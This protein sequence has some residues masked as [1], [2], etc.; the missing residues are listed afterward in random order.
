MV[1][2]LCLFVIPQP[3]YPPTHPSD[4]IAIVSDVG[5]VI[6]VVTKIKKTVSETLYFGLVL[7]TKRFARL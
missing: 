6:E 2:T 7:L 4:V 3:S 1:G 5:D